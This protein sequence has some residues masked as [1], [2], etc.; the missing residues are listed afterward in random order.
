MGAHRE[1]TVKRI[2]TELELVAAGTTV[3][4]DPIDLSTFA[5]SGYFTLQYYVQGA[6]ASV[7]M[8]FKL[9]NDGVNYVDST[10]GYKI[11]TGTTALH[12]DSGNARDGR[13]I[14]RF[15]PTVAPLM[16]LCAWE[17][18]SVGASLTLSLALQ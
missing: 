7:N 16:K 12:D 2:W 14:I 9:C 1:V 10:E 5:Q 3:T 6:G 13:D 4:S 15:M 18:Q 17:T 8:T 11:V